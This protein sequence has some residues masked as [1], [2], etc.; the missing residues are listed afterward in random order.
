MYYH[1]EKITRN[2]T[3]PQY[4]YEQKLAWKKEVQ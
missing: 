4:E 3:Q 1:T 2:Y